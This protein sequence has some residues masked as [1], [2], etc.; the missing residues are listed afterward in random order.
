[1]TCVFVWLAMATPRSR[2]IWFFVYFNRVKFMHPKRLPLALALLV[3]TLVAGLRVIN[4]DFP[5]RLERMTYDLRVRLAR[6]GNAPVSTNLVFVS[7]ED[8]T[9]TAVK[10]GALGY[11]FGLYWPR[12]VYGR[13]VEELVAEKA[14]TVAFD[15]LFA[16]RRPDHPPV[17]MANGDLMESDVFFATQMRLAG[18]VLLATTPEARPPAL[19]TTNALALGDISTEKDSDG[20]LRRARAFRDLRRWHPCFEKLAADP[21]IRADLSRAKLVSGKILIPQT[22]TT[23]FIKVSVDAENEFLI[24]DFT[25][26]PPPAGADD[27]A[28]AF[29]TERVWHLGIQLAAQELGLDLKQ[30]QVNLA[31]GKII[32][33]GKNDVK[34]VIPVDAQGYFWVNWGLSLPR[35][36]LEQL[37]AQDR[38]RL[39][40]KPTGAHNELAGKLVVVGSAAQGNDLTDRGATPL[41]SDT[42]LVSKHWNIANSIISNR[43]IH[44]T[45]LPTD[46]LIILALGFLTALLT[47]QFRA[48][49][50]STLVGL[51]L[52]G[53]AALAGWYF[54]RHQWWL[55]V[56]YPLG[57]ALLL[58]HFV[59][60]VHRV[61]FEEREK[62]HVKSV[63][64]RIVSPDVVNELLESD[65]LA[66]GGARREV[67]VLFADVRG[68]TH[69]T[70]E[71]QQTIGDFIKVKHL[72]EAT[73]EKCVD[74]FARETLETVNLYLSAVA[75]AVKKHNGTLDKYIGD[76]VMAFWGAP[77][78]NPRHAHAAVLA[79]IDAQRAIEELNQ[80]RT[81]QSLAREMENR[82][83]S[84]AGLPPKPPL[85][86]LQLGT[87]INTG[88]VTV[89]L[90]GSD[91]HILNYTV[92]GREVNL[93]SR[94]ESVSGSGRIIISAT[95]YYHL[96][97]HA[98]E[99]SATCMEMFPARLKGFQDAVRNYEVPWQKPAEHK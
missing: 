53:Y 88:Y 40:G 84:V 50:A 12:Q 41:E 94:L 85:R 63:F 29:T 34:R 98:P 66:L 87:G 82:A 18:N 78:G 91:K 14:K 74:E 93:A 38:L 83:R 68:F 49:I 5:D 52:V 76:C 81:D 72:D 39:Q 32:L 80:H 69:L 28:K 8:S 16:E 97:R 71:M 79:A 25:G 4:P 60:V 54:F 26:S 7:M 9:L 55:P 67:T 27:K 58:Q 77:V 43:F 61:I 96:L 47:W 42:L 65:K 70:D 86:A 57:G 45:D 51:L 1:M 11:R 33:R 17:Q 90:M 15:V 13:L 21:E 64:S 56:V 30:A 36:P 73:A 48:W 2:L 99:I 3:L 19:F 31:Q 22:G 24:S 20:I 37:L 92:F 44:R 59:L 95:T 46:L 75:D 62:R 89:G 10:S 6:D 35:I 23:N